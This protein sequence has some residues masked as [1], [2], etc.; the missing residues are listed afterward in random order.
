VLVWEAAYGKAFAIEV[1][2]DGQAWTEVYRTADGKGGREEI[3]FAPV[4]ARWVRM[5]GTKRATQFGY[6]LYEFSVFP[7]P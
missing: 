2:K 4:E 6:S 3:R 7:A 5:T 1:S